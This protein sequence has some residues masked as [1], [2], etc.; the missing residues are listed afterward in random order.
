MSTHGIGNQSTPSIVII[1][2]GVAGLSAG[3]FARANG[4]DTTILEKHTVLGGECTGWDRKGYHIDGCIHWLMGTKEGTPM[5]D[6]WKSVGALDGVEIYH[7]DTFLTFEHEAGTVPIYRD[8]DRLRQAWLDLSPRDAD[9]IE[10]FVATIRQMGAFEMETTKPMDM[11]SLVEKVRYLASMKE[12]G[13]VLRRYGKVG[14]AEYA[15]RFEHPAIRAMFATFAPGDYAVAF[16]FFGLATFAQGQSSIPMGG[17]KAL[18][19]RMAE[20]YLALGGKVE[21]GCEVTGVTID[22]KRVTHLQTA[23]GRTFAADHYIAACDANVVFERLLGG[24]YRDPAFAKRFDDP[25]TYPL[26]SNTYIGL[27][28]E[29]GVGDMPRTVRFDCEPI[30]LGNDA[31]TQITLN[32]YAYEPDFAP[33]GHTALTVALNHFGEAVDHWLALAGDREAYRREKE[34][35]GETVREAIEAHVPHFAGKLKVLDVATPATYERYCNAHR[36]A[37][38]AFFPTIGS[39]MMAHTGRIKGLDNFVL[40]GQ[41]LQ[42]PGGLPIAV[43]TGK[44]SIQR[45]CKRLK[46]PFVGPL[47]PPGEQ[48]RQVA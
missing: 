45:L 31:I 12:A 21:T 38:M 46:R 9:A 27:G 11:M 44:D 34:R 10:E 43:I 28:L 3:I 47:T 1:G 8:L 5:N 22:R 29:A 32:H 26:A 48:R 17:S 35:V 20:R 13:A 14:L 40:S 19:D 24:R 42:P 33:E 39:K 6:L 36:G 37:F 15:K 4:F 25:K 18:A 16:L 30:A 23:D 41:W 2:G 7:P